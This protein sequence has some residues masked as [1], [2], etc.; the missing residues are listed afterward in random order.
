M[1]YGLARGLGAGARDAAARQGRAERHG[2]R[3]A[4]Q[5]EAAARALGLHGER[6]GRQPDAAGQRRGVQD[7]SAAPAP[8][9]GRLEDR[10]RR[11]ALRPAVRQ[12]HLPVPGGRPSHV[13]HRR[14]GG[15][16]PRGQGEERAAGALDARPRSRVEDVAAARGGGLWYQLYMP[17]TWDDTEK[18]VRRVEAA[19]CPVLVWTIDLLG[20]RNLETATRVQRTDT[21]QCEACHAT[22]HRRAPRQRDVPRPQ[23]RALQPVQRHLGLGGPLEEDD[24]DEGRPEGRRDGGGRAARARERRRRHPGVEPRR[25]R[26]RDAARPPSTSCPRSWTR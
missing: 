1:A 13:P 7:H 24:V 19:G 8:P 16:R 11:R 9:G 2:L 25:P 22:R 5:A 20:G 3:S 17:P 26:R 18:L 23:Q 14:R 10:H 12:P 4:R 15:D 6:R 21:R